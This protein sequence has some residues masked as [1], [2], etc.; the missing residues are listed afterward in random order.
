MP[1]FVQNNYG[2]F[3]SHQFKLSNELKNEKPY[4]IVDKKDVKV[5]NIFD[6][7]SN[8]DEFGEKKFISIKVFKNFLWE[9]FRLKTS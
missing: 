9:Y 8:I 6:C 4:L 2:N 3:L 5:T 7:S 1:V